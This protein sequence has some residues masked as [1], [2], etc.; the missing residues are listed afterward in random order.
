VGSAFAL[1]LLWVTSIAARDVVGYWGVHGPS[2]GEKGLK[3]YCDTGAYTIIN[4]AFIDKLSSAKNIIPNIPAAASSNGDVV[5]DIK[6]CQSKGIK[7]FISIGGYIANV[8]ISDSSTGEQYATGLWNSFF[9]G[10]DST[11]AR[12][13]KNATLDGLDLDLEQASTSGYVALVN[14]LKGYFDASGKRYYLSAAPQCGIP[15]PNMDTI[16][17]SVWFDYVHAQFYNNWCYFTGPNFNYAHVNPQFGQSWVQFSSSFKNKN[18]KLL[19]GVPAPGGGN[20][21]DYDV[22]PHLQS[23]VPGLAKNYTSL[24]GG[25][26]YWDVFWADLYG[27]NWAHNVKAL[28]DSSF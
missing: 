2:V 28:V 14:K 13:F 24:F 11:Y 16:L 17:K 5:A 15:D 12:P 20:A 8:P 9:G 1:V 22:Y 3:F 21:G 27:K 4:L 7:I 26:M 23:V 10:S 25:V 6:Y 19:L 18:T